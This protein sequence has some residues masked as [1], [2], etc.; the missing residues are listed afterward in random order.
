MF[1]LGVSGAFRAFRAFPLVN[2]CLMK[3]KTFFSQNY[4]QAPQRYSKSNTYT[5][6]LG[7]TQIL[8]LEKAES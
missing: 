7:R 5:I 6:E 1:P 2:E 8:P 4:F 3:P